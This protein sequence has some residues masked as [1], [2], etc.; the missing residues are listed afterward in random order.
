MLT[1]STQSG[2][3]LIARDG[4]PVTYEQR[5]EVATGKCSC[6]CQ[7]FVESIA[8]RAARAGITPTI[9]NGKTCCHL[10]KAA[11]W[12]RERG[13]LTS[14]PAPGEAVAVIEVEAPAEPKGP[15]FDYVSFFEKW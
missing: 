5:I 10:R 2:R 14:E 9:H 13:Y 3:G 7:G 4:F 8:P 6:T 11:E 15:D 12:G 1:T